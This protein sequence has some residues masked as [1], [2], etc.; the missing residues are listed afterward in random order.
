METSFNASLVVV[1][2]WPL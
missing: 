2:M 1:S